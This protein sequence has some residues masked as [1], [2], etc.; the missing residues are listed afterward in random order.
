MCLGLTCI[1]GVIV[2]QVL[3]LFFVYFKVWCVLMPRVG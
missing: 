2:T 3:L 1:L